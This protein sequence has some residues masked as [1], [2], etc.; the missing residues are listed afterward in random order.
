MRPPVYEAEMAD[1]PALVGIPE[2]ADLLGVSAQRVKQ[3]RHD[4]DFP[5]P[6]IRLRMGPAW[7]VVDILGW[8]EANAERRAQ[9]DPRKNKEALT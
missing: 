5:P 3:L 8:A 1:P 7:W 6:A 9:R 2:A 4:P